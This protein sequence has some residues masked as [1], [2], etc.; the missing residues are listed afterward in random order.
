[1]KHIRTLTQESE[2]LSLP[3]DIPM[4]IDIV[5]AVIVKKEMMDIGQ[6]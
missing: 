4:W 6:Q 3:G 5:L 2:K 1:M